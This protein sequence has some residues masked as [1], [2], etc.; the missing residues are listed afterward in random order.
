MTSEVYVY[1]PKLVQQFGIK[2]FFALKV[3]YQN[4]YYHE[5]STWHYQHYIAYT[6]SLLCSLIL[7][8][9]IYFN[10]AMPIPVKLVMSVSKPLWDSFDYGSNA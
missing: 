10:D 5:T 7:E 9:I 3:E 6:Q 1:Y 2:Y 8:K 4:I